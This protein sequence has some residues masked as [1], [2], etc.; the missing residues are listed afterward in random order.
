MP[1]TRFLFARAK[2][3]TM[4]TVSPAT[5]TTPACP[6]LS[7]SIASLAVLSQPIPA[8]TT[9]IELNLIAIR[10]ALTQ[11]EVALLVARLLACQAATL[12]ISLGPHPEPFANVFDQLARHFADM[13]F[14]HVKL[15]GYL[16][17]R[18]LL[19]AVLAKTPS[20]ECTTQ[21]DSHLPE[22]LDLVSAP[23]CVLTTLALTVCNSAHSH[24]VIAALASSRVVELDL[25][26]SDLRDSFAKLA[27]ALPSTQI[28][29]LKLKNCK[30]TLDGL[31]ELQLRNCAH[32]RYLVLSGNKLGCAGAQLVAKQLEDNASLRALE[33]NQC[34]VGRAGLLALG[35]ALARSR[36]SKLALSYNDVADGDV[37]D[38]A[39][40]VASSKL[41]TLEM[42][43]SKC[44]QHGLAV[45][46]DRVLGDP[47]CLLL[48]VNRNFVPHELEARLRLV[49]VRE[50]LISLLSAKTAFLAGC[51]VKRLPKELVRVLGSML[52]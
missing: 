4:T 29:T 14:T 3:T 24:S 41:I 46:F 5:T 32:L 6:S 16:V 51:Q 9:T 18:D 25:K 21:L 12:Q 48:Y 40:Q 27:Q 36:L 33:M 50:G 52:L 11:Q 10:R 23:S 44:T 19:Q 22:H 8:S 31:G 13:P 7:L 39:A 20:L 42:Y 37:F 2:K 38:F 43:G 35:Q 45:A 47:S 1:L 28:A 34:Q 17:H 26:A 15:D 30:L 49:A